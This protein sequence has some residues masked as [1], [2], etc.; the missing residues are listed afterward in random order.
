MDPGTSVL[1]QAS[2]PLHMLFPCLEGTLLLLHPPGDAP[3]YSQPPLLVGGELSLLPGTEESGTC[4]SAP[5][6]T[7]KTQTG[8]NTIDNSQVSPRNKLQRKYTEKKE[9]EKS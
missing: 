1:D 3:S 2:N 7:G 9:E 4:S 6:S 8:E 5:L